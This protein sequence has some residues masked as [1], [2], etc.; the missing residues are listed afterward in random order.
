MNK[1]II[2]DL[3][4]RHHEAFARLVMNPKHVAPTYHCGMCDVDVDIN[5][6]IYDHTTSTSPL[7]P[8]CNTLLQWHYQIVE[9]N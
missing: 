9:H 1:D 4:R 6:V 8:H 2:D 7:C 3:I 5:H